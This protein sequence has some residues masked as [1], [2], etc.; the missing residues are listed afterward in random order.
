MDERDAVRGHEKL[1][2]LRQRKLKPKYVIVVCGVDQ[3]RGWRWWSELGDIPEVEIEPKDI[4]G[5]LDL[6][7]AHGL[8]LAIIGESE[9]RVLDFWNA[10]EKVKPNKMYALMNWD[11]SVLESEDGD[12]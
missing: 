7:W 11:N 5:K 4:I 9:D 2:E 10:A 8:D 6:R 3:T 12:E 1:I